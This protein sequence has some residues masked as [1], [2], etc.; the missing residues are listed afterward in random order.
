[1][2]L[3]IIIP[4][5]NMPNKDFFLK[6]C[7]ESVESQSLKDYEILQIEGGSFAEN[8]NVG[9]KKAKGDLIK[10]L[11][12]DDWL[13]PDCLQKVVDNFKGGWLITGCSDNPHPYWTQVWTGNNKLGSPSC[14]TIQND[15]IYFIDS[16]QIYFDEGLQWMVDTDFYMKLYKRYGEPIVLDEVNVNIGIHPGQMTHQISEEVKIK[17]ITLMKEKYG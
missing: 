12:I 6:R 11:C 4:I 8:C 9:I 3:S 2:K 16:P 14:L 17:E 1:M 13:S 5:H 10:F 7:L 15:P